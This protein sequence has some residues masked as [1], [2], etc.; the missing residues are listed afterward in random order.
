MSSN[1]PWWVVGK[2]PNVVIMQGLPPAAVGVVILVLSLRE[3]LFAWVY[4]IGVAA[5]LLG[6]FCICSGLLHHRLIRSG[7]PPR[8]DD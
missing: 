7:N 6:G 3:P 2:Y 1:K 4:V 5:L 8:F